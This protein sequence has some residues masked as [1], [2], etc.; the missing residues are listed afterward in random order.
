MCPDLW[1]VLPTLR[2]VQ[3]MA[4][5]KLLSALLSFLTFLPEDVKLQDIRA[6]RWHDNIKGTATGMAASSQYWY[7]VLLAGLLFKRVG[8]VAEG[9]PEVT[10]PLWRAA[11]YLV[12]SSGGKI[13]KGAAPCRPPKHED[14]IT[15]AT[16]SVWKGLTI[17]E[18]VRGEAIYVG[19][20]P[21]H[22]RG[23]TF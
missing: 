18:K 7:N 3:V 13:A 10:M 5:G 23:I 11:G 2:Y 1:A 21:G 19:W 15:K 4:L 6:S 12:S 17:K 16:T 20:S 22:A 9:R 14:T 8:R